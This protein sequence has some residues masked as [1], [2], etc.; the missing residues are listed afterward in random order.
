MNRPELPS[1]VSGDLVACSLPATSDSWISLVDDVWQSGA[2][3]LPV[4]SRLPATTRDAMIKRARATVVIAPDGAAR[5]RHPAG[6]DEAL[7]AVVATSGSTGE[8][9]LIEL[10]RDAVAAAVA[11]SAEV[12]G[13]RPDDAWLL[14]LPPSHIGGLLV[15]LRHALTSAPVVIGSGSAEGLARGDAAFTSLVPTQLRR[16]LDAGADLTRFRAILVGG[17]ALA[18]DLAAGAR[19]R[20]LSLV[21]TYGLTESCGGVVYDG[22][23][24]PRTRVRIGEAGEVQLAGPTLLRG[25]RADPSATASAFTD[26]GW[27]RTRDAGEMRDGVLS[28]RGRLDDAIRSGGETVWPLEVEAVLSSHPQV[29]EVAVAGAEDREWGER[30]VAFV[31]PRQTSSPPTLESLR[32]HV[33]ERLP[34]YKAPRQLII[35]A[36][37]PRTTPDNQ[38]GKVRRDVL[39][40]ATG[41][42]SGGEHWPPGP[43][44]SGS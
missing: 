6:R 9:R 3:L 41:A 42:R 30:V 43:P 31:V 17:S 11:A 7:L 28:V 29:A 14:C 15:L 40:R 18:P 37:L 27:L 39:R 22:R 5:L 24:L 13:S 32:A 26:D 12:I 2:A 21:S 23:A 20:D 36:T 38:G 16:L 44:G 1:V 4:D 19:A 35:T 8:P 25:Y 33:S 10:T 34:R